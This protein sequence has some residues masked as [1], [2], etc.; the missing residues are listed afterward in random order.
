MPNILI[1]I[2]L[3]PSFFKGLI[4]SLPRIMALFLKWGDHI[5]DDRAHFRFSRIN[6]FVVIGLNIWIILYGNQGRHIYS[7]D[8]VAK[9]TKFVQTIPR[10]LLIPKYA[11]PFTYQVTKIPLW[12][13]LMPLYDQSAVMLSEKGSD[14]DQTYRGASNKKNI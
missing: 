10:T 4:V 9:S 3:Y 7:C 12:S 11:T 8:N 2:L 1:S 6:Q 5:I 14:D 13:K